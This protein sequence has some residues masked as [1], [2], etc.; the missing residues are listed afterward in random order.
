MVGLMY[1]RFK[2]I[3]RFWVDAWKF[4]LLWNGK[5]FWSGIWI[6]DSYSSNS[7]NEGNAGLARP[8]KP[9]EPAK[10]TRKR[11]RPGES[12]RP[13]A[14]PGE[15]TRPRP[16]DRSRSKTVSKS[17]EGSLIIPHGGKVLQTFNLG[18]DTVTH[19]KLYGVQYLERKKKVIYPYTIRG[20]Y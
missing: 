18:S 12:T 3:S 20:W 6:D 1:W 7:I 17:W 5:M 13:R 16:K 19:N 11:A 14:R 10:A 4:P 9:E 2:G 15:S 8:Q